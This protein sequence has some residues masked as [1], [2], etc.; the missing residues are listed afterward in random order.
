[1]V[2]G[3][4]ACIGLNYLGGPQGVATD[5]VTLSFRKEELGP[6][7][8]PPTTVAVPTTI[9]DDTTPPTTTPDP[10]TAITTTTTVATTT[11][12]VFTLLVRVKNIATGLNVAGAQVKV[13]A[14][15]EVLTAT[16]LA[17]QAVSLTVP[18]ATTFSI[19]CTATGFN[20]YTEQITNSGGASMQLIV[21]LNP[22]MANPHTIR[23]VL[24]W[25][26]CP[27]DLDAELGVPWST[28]QV[29]SWEQTHLEHAQTQVAVNLVTQS[30]QAGG[31]ETIEIVANNLAAINQQCY[32]F[33]HN[34]HIYSN[35]GGYAKSGAMVTVFHN[36]SKLLSV[37][38]VAPATGAYDTPDPCPQ[39]ATC[40]E[41]CA[42][43]CQYSR[44]WYTTLVQVRPNGQ[45]VAIPV[46]KVQKARQPLPLVTTCSQADVQGFVRNIETNAGLAG[47]TV[48]LQSLVRHYD[49][50]TDAQG[51]FTGDVALDSYTVSV[52]DATGFVVPTQQLAATTAGTYKLLLPAAPTATTHTGY[53]VALTWSACPMDLDINVVVPWDSTPVAWDHPQS[54]NGAATM[55]ADLLLESSAGYGIETVAISR[56][57][58]TLPASTCFDFRVYSH[59][60]SNCAGYEFA[61]AHAYVFSPTALLSQSV[62]PTPSVG[63]YDSPDP[64]P[65]NRGRGGCF[66]E[67]ETC[68]LSC[69]YN[70]TWHSFKFSLATTSDANSFVPLS[71]VQNHA[72]PLPV[73]SATCVAPTQAP[74]CL[75]GTYLDQGACAPCP[76]GTYAATADASQCVPFTTCQPFEAETFAGSPS[77]DRECTRYQFHG[78]VLN[79]VTGSGMANTTIWLNTTDSSL[80]VSTDAQ[81]NFSILLNGTGLFTLQVVAPQHFRAR[82]TD[83]VSLRASTTSPVQY[84]EFVLLT[85]PTPTDAVTVTLDWDSCPHDLDMYLM[86]PWSTR[87]VG[88]GFGTKSTHPTL[89]ITAELVRASETATEGIEQFVISGSDLLTA[90]STCFRFAVFTQIY[91]NCAGYGRSSATVTVAD[92]KPIGQTA[93][94]APSQGNYDTPDPCPELAAQGG[95]ITS[96]ASTC[97][98][99]RI[100]H[101]MTFEVRLGL[102]SAVQPV[103]VVQADV[104]PLPYTLCL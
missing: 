87:R 53:R 44:I 32:E 13:T 66:N 45:V 82:G 79:G 21:P 96:C 77:A 48:R 35:C 62:A 6:T 19:E 1:M 2:D 37:P 5:Q 94:P 23:I 20:K 71:K 80:A 11:K 18:L 43:A 25:P 89:N 46:N 22:T 17:G 83:T 10:S 61:R 3:N 92:T 8:E 65:G 86:V 49:V 51:A 69:L 14:N 57:P 27:A 75:P 97:R 84:H 36:N 54:S 100:W 33:R 55:R 95:C 88:Y 59:V 29:V 39:L 101:A 31:V 78:A 56:P 99:R 73:V 60:Y 42:T 74:T 90:S 34:V 40:T 4:D 81:G 85:E 41:D 15:G 76:T 72:T 67:D 7:T 64:C 9:A 28:T 102:I 93:V 16:S 58:E 50:V 70:R 47:V 52:L 104:A 103:S 24:T 12:P 68:S 30:E 91:S 63:K 38:V 26:S 98:Y